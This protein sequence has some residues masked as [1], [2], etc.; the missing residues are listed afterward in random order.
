MQFDLMWEAIPK[1][2]SGIPVTLL[3]ATAAISLGFVIAIG[4][5]LSIAAHRPVLGPI[6]TASP[7]LDSRRHDVSRPEEGARLQVED[8]D[9]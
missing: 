5:A 8:R 2:A 3:L 4:S 6:G 9:R 1:I 7:Q